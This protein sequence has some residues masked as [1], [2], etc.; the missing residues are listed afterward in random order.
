MAFW[1]ISLQV[2]TLR[3]PQLLALLKILTSQWPTTSRKLPLEVRQFRK[4]CH[5]LTVV[6]GVLLRGTQI[7]VPKGLR[8]GMLSRAHAGH[9]GIAKTKA[10][11]REVIWWPGMGMGAQIETVLSQCEVCSISF[12][13]AE[14]TPAAIA[15]SRSPLAESCG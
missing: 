13:T 4:F 10:R 2:E 8:A 1:T 6:D 5:L 11:A 3:D 15:V 12:A 7:V 9:Q 14:R